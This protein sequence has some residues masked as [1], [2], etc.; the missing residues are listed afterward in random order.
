M[1]KS[2]IP[3]NDMLTAFY[4]AA[5][6]ISLS[7]TR[8]AELTQRVTGSSLHRDTVETYVKKKWSSLIAKIREVEASDNEIFSL[9]DKD[10]KEE[11][12]LLKDEFRNLPAPI[13]RINE[14]QVQLRR[15]LLDKVT[16]NYNDLSTKDALRFL[17]EIDEGLRQ[18]I[19]KDKSRRELISEI[20]AR[21]EIFFDDNHDMKARLIT[22]KFEMIENIDT[23]I[24][25]LEA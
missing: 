7:K 1:S 2:Q 13:R 16:G 3:T 20:F 4:F 15:H 6:P 21:L 19:Y 12:T 5:L 22:K 17:L 14:R 18:T 8:I 23:E 11:D 25:Q 9:N 24:K 10:K